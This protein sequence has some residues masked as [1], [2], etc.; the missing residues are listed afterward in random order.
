[1]YQHMRNLRARRPECL[2]DSIGCALFLGR[3]IETLSFHIGVVQ[4][5]FM[6]HAWV[7]SGDLLMNDGKRVIDRYSEILRVDL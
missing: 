2:E 1:M 5:A 7:Q 4:P 3:Y 6:A